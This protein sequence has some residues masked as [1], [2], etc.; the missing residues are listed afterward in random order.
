MLVFMSCKAHSQIT[1]DSTWTTYTTKDSSMHWGLLGT[2]T[3][4]TTVR[5]SQPPDTLKVIMFCADTSF[6][7]GT[8]FQL[9][10]NSRDTATDVDVSVKNRIP[11]CFWLFGYEIR[12]AAW[13]SYLD[14][15]KKPLSKKIMVWMSIPD[16]ISKWTDARNATRGGLIIQQ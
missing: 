9:F 13:S 16:L 3:N 4:S 11:L 12:N 1:I 5:I 10:F 8:E 7:E 2:A 6:K 15:N 14:E